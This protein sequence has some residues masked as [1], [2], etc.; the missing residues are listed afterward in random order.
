[1]ETGAD[2]YLTKP[3]DAS[4]LRLR[5]AKLIERRHQLQK[6]FASRVVVLG[7][8]E[9]DL[10]HQETVFLERIEGIIEAHMSRRQLLASGAASVKE[11]ANST[12]FKSV[13]YFT[14]VFGEMYGSPP[15][16]YGEAERSRR[17]G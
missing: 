16:A 2:A 1:M 8:A 13:P 6:R 15:S 12:G 14:K 4:E 7:A 3:F 9:L 5:V 17:A 10:P 11:V